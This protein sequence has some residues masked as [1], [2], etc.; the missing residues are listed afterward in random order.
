M[1]RI[2]ISSSVAKQI[3]Q[4]QRRVGVSPLCEN[5]CFRRFFFGLCLRRGGRIAPKCRR[6]IGQVVQRVVGA[7]IEQG[8]VTSEQLHEQTAHTPNIRRR[9][10]RRTVSRHFGTGVE[11]RADEALV[12]LLSSRHPAAAAAAVEWVVHVGDMSIIIRIAQGG[13]KCRGGGRIVTCLC[14]ASEV[15]EFRGPTRITSEDNVVSLDVLVHHVRLLVQ[16]AK[17]AEHLPY[18]ERRVALREGA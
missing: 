4:Q 15:T 10:S 11:G 7:A 12:A 18:V 14:R 17:P 1:R 13:K 8:R 3:E 9:L 6:Q 5:C 16:V 2:D